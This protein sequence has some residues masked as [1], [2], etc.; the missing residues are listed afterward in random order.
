MLPAVIIWL[1]I[2]IVY[3]NLEVRTIKYPNYRARRTRAKNSIRNL[4][5]ENELTKNDLIH[6]VFVVEGEGIK[7]EIPSMPEV[8]HLSLDNLESEIEELLELGV[9][10]LVVFGVPDREHRC[11]EGTKA[12]DPEGIT[13][14]AIRKI[15]GLTDRLTVF[16]DVCLCAYTSHG[17]CGSVREERVVNDR[18]LDL[19]ARVALSHAEAGADFVAPSAMM[20][21]QVKAIRSKLESNDF[22][23]VGIMAYSA[24]YHS[25]FYGPFRDAADSSPDFGD[26]SKYQMDP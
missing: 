8:Y 5:R 9:P 22:E 25:N 7:R 16:S 12:Y 21:G 4:V 18:T 19:L 15:K 1:P 6:P 2:L 3:T 24:K 13:Q 23:N 10:G 26:R 11:P 14:R 20:D 17:H